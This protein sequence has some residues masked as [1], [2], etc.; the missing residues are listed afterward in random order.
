[1]ADRPGSLESVG[2][3]SNGRHPRL[4]SCDECPR[5][6]RSPSSSSSTSSPLPLPPP[7]FSM[8]F[9][10]SCSFARASPFLPF[11]S[12]ILRGSSRF[13]AHERESR[14]T[15]SVES[16]FKSAN[17]KLETSDRA[18]TGCGHDK[19][20]RA[21]APLRVAPSEPAC[22]I[23]RSVVDPRGTVMQLGFMHFVNP[24]HF[25]IFA[26]FQLAFAH[27]QTRHKSENIKKRF[28]RIM[29]TNENENLCDVK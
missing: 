15:D 4:M 11:H 26:R 17:R 25:S 19:K 27:T 20:V 7:S 29:N 23:C 12:A 16:L 1:M 5:W 18:A 14:M 22:K 10:L 24:V 8:L 9:F 6:T 21:A 2:R 13:L 28:V 3:V